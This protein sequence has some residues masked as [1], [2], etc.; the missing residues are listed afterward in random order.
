MA[1]IEVDD[2][3]AFAPAPAAAIGGRLRVTGG[4]AGA[5]QHGS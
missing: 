4:G 5:E 2:L 1:P 3:L